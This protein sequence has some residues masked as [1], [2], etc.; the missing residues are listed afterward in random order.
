MP[1]TCLSACLSLCLRA[2]A[3]LAQHGTHAYAPPALARLPLSLLLTASHMP[4]AALW[5][6]ARALSYTIAPY[7]CAAICLIFRQQASPAMLL[8]L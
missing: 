8:C 1:L 6:N 2:A 4:S 5:E 7:L 3:T